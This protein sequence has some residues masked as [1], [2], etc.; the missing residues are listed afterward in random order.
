SPDSSHFIIQIK[1]NEEILVIK[2]QHSDEVVGM[3]REID[4]MKELLKTIMKQQNPH[5]SDEE[6]S[7]MMATTL[8]SSNSTIA[9]LVAPHSSASTHIPHSEE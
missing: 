9:A 5:V 7:N 4:G 6:I 1:R 8:G 3:K 2:K